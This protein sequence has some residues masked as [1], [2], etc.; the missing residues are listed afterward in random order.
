[1]V[2]DDFDNDRDMDIIVFPQG[3]PP[4]GWVNDRAGNYHRLDAG[5]M[6]LPPLTNVLG[7]TTGDVDND[8]NRDLLIFTTGPAYLFLNR[9]GFRFK[10]DEA[11]TGLCGRLGASGGQFADMDNDGDLDIVVADALRPGDTRG[12]ALFI[13]EWPKPG[14]VRAEQVDPGNLLATLSF[15]GYA[16]CIAADFTGDGRVDILL[17]P[18]GG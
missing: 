16:S 8:G 2:C 11:F 7:A 10:Q 6:G 14:F 5:Q 1:M 4:I 12:P 15:K 13:N 3:A 17:A 9:G 18:A